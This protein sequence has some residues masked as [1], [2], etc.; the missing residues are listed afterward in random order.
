[1]DFKR[2]LSFI[3]EA[4]GVPGAAPGVAPTGTA[5]A[6]VAAPSQAAGTKAQQPGQAQSK[7]PDL[8][9]FNKQISDKISQALSKE[10][11]R[12]APKITKYVQDSLAKV[13]GQAGGS[14]GSPSLESVVGVGSVIGEEESLPANQAVTVMRKLARARQAGE[15]LG[16]IFTG[17]A[18]R[19]RLG[20][21]DD[22]L[23]T[24]WGLG[25]LRRERGGFVVDLQAVGRELTKHQQRLPVKSS[26][27][28]G[29]LKSLLYKLSKMT[30]GEMSKATFPDVNAVVQRLGLNNAE[31]QLAQSKN[32]LKKT[33]AGLMIDKSAVRQAYDATMK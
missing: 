10:M 24:A 8:T 4:D 12:V 15:Q 29:N 11:A 2:K 20:L 21:T 23:R 13:T 18:L 3:F 17:E 22:E 28:T 16:S 33:T 1:M 7:K 30:I 14:S 26:V 25:M 19:S 31:L 9:N 6:G 27:G 5:S 32:I